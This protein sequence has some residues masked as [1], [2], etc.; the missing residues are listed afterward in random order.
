MTAGLDLA[1]PAALLLLPVGLVL[2][3]VLPPLA[4]PGAALVLP[5]RLAARAGA[6]AA[7]GRGSRAGLGLAIWVLLVIALAGP[8]Q[9]LPVPALQVS[10]RDM[11][12]ALDLSGSMVREDF[13]LD[14]QPLSRLA[15]VQRVGAAF[16]RGRAG[17]RLALIV[18]G[19]EAYYAAPFTFDTDSIARRIEE[20]AIGISGRATNIADALGLALRRMARSEATTRV[21]VLLS[22]G[23]SNA[24]S[25]DPLEAAQLAARMGVRVHT[26]ALGPLDL[27][28]DPEA[29]A[30]VDSQT[31]RQ[32]AELSGGTAWRVR[33]MADLTAVIDALDRLEASPAEGLAAEIHRPLWP[34]PAGLAGLLAGALAWRARP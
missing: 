25:A 20:A 1:D 14:G 18:F 32:I 11:A 31:L 7:G 6:G 30:A 8:R 19:S 4:T 12:I 9:L 33:D 2:W 13:T 34:W 5:P 29:R 27:E 26:I 21:I 17:D 24:G 22:D 3:R 23:A 15:A 16:A 28:T 10:G